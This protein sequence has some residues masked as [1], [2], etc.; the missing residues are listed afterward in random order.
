MGK[1]AEKDSGSVAVINVT[2]FVDVMLVLLIIFMIVSTLSVAAEDA[3]ADLDL[4]VTRDNPVDV[5]INNPANFILRID[6]RLVVTVG[7]EEIT[8]CS[9]ALE[10]VEATRFEP[11]FDEIE[12][13]LGRNPRLAE[14]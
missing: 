13:K 10:L 9:G 2:P 3:G 4:P 6:D 1:H 11:C 5:D 8:N 7:E 14:E 12:R